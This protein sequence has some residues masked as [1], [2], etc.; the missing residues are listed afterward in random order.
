[1]K[2]FRSIVKLEFG[3]NGIE[4]ESKEQYIEKLKEA[5]EQEFNIELLDKEITQIEEVEE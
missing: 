2:T 5:F 4:A 3:G 1:M